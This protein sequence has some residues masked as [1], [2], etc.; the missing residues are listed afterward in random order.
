[1]KAIDV[2]N[3]MAKAKTKS[4]SKAELEKMYLPEATTDNG[5]G[6]C[7]AGRYAFGKNEVEAMCSAK[8]LCDEIKHELNCK[9]ITIHKLHSMRFTRQGYRMFVFM[10]FDA[11]MIYELGGRKAGPYND[12]LIRIYDQLHVKEMREILLKLVDD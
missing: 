3:I 9:K 6:I 12:D 1:M 2:L 7:F 10:H 8:D 11:N 5:L 4:Y